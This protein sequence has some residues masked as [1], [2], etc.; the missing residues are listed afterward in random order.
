MSAL[1]EL[2]S[3]V[4][5]LAT[6]K[7][8]PTWIRGVLLF[9]ADQATA[10]MGTVT[11]PMLTLVVQG[12]KRSVL[13]EHVFEHRRGQ[14]AAVTVDLPL[15]SQIVE[16]SPKRPFLALGMRL[17]P[18]VIAQLL[19]EGGSVTRPSTNGLGMAISD[20]NDDVLDAIL[21]LIRLLDAPRDYGVLAPNVRR[22]IYW[23]LLNGPQAALLK[24][25]GAADSRVALVA[26]AIEWIRSRYDQA[27]RID[28]LAMDLGTS[29]SSLNRHF[30]AVTAISPLQYQKQIRLQKARMELM[31]APHNVAEI[32][33]AVG[34]ENPSQFSREYRRMFGA[35]PRQDA[36]RLQTMTIVQE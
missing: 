23:R 12:T 8:R 4:T 3:H 9:A 30:R 2:G 10:P 17:E 5:R 22:E 20:A 25:V 33:Y 19:A 14:I 35:P 27:I 13:G 6:E 18:P 16:A 21:R 24:Q 7:S 36:L 34:Y 15:V 11:E 32:G 29:V 31:A 26:R 28:D 1:D